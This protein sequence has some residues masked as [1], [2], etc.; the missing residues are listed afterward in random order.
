MKKKD[1]DTLFIVAGSAGAGKS[2]IIRSSFLLDIRLFGE[3]FHS[4]F[5]KTCTSPNHEEIKKY[6]DAREL[7]SIFQARHLS[8]L[9]RD[10]SPPA[11]LLLHI[12]LRGVVNQLGHA[13]AVRS[14]RKQIEEITEIPIPQKLMAKPELCDLMVSGYLSNPLFKRFDKILV[15]TITSSFSNNSQQLLKR[16]FP[17]TTKQEI[18]K[19]WKHLGFKKRD[20]AQKFHKEVY[21]SWERN[22]HILQPEGIYFTKVS[23]GGDLLVNNEIACKGWS[24]KALKN[25]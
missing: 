19:K 10:P 17:S 25:H 15:N 9:A 18:Q 8:A 5:Q 4:K 20:L 12:D 23:E 24:K 13:A 21:K 7:G 11:C 14:H 22:I 1:L 2:T 3:D 16:K 6:S